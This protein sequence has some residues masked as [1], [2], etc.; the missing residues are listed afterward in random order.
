MIAEG[1]I[2]NRNFE[3]ERIMKKAYATPIA[4]KIEFRY[5]RVVAQSGSSCGIKYENID[6]DG[7]NGCDH[8]IP[9]TKVN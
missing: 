8:Q 2:Q 3:E 4:E 9:V 6:N 1:L 5:E 7:V